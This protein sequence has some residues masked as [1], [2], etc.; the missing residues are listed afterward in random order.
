MILVQ[1]VAFGANSSLLAAVFAMVEVMVALVVAALLSNEDLDAFAAKA[2]P[3]IALYAAAVAWGATPLLL[4]LAGAPHPKLLAPDAIGLELLKLA[5]LGAVVLTGALVASDRSRMNRLILALVTMGLAYTILSLWIGQATPLSVWGQSKGPHT[6]RFTGTLLNAN[7]AGC[8]FGMLGLLS[9]GTLQDRFQRLDLRSSGLTDYGLLAVSVC[10][11]LAAFGACVL[12]QSR[13]SLFLSLILGA[14]LVVVE[15]RNR[16]RPSRILAASV[17]AVLLG[18]LGFGASQIASRWDSLLADAGVRVEAYGHYLSALMASPLFGYGLGAFKTF[19]ESMLT[20]ELAPSM[21]DYG[22]AHS[23]FIQSAIEGGAPFVFFICAALVMMVIAIRRG[24]SVRHGMGSL[25]TGAL[26]A[27]G[28]AV[29]CSFVDIALNVPAV[30]AFA[31]LLLG[32]VWG[33]SLS[34]RGSSRAT[35]RSSRAPVVAEGLHG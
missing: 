23:A 35:R 15:W 17:I 10:G 14:I 20:P 3:V 13:T 21:W 28:L 32:A 18:G 9:L 7:A 25:A 22:A 26:A 27:A 31:A 12:T 34:G 5:G 19:H 33:R 1:F 24:A 4:A 8:L 30:A 11:A 29:I 6:F 16:R 2:V